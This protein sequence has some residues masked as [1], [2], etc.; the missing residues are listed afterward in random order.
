M[1]VF[2]PEAFP[3]IPAQHR[4]LYAMIASWMLFK[5]PPDH[6]RLRR[7]AA[8]VFA[9]RSVLAMRGRLEELVAAALAKLPRRGA[10]AVVSAFSSPL[11]I[12][13]GSYLLGVPPPAPPLIRGWVP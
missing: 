7:I 8:P 6:G 13:I 12:D 3:P 9:A 5:D 1:K 2:P 4:P 10:V 11:S